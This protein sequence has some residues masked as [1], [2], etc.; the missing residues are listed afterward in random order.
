MDYN[1][2]P[3]FV[4]G[5]LRHF[6]TAS[7][8]V[9]VSKMRLQGTHVFVVCWAGHASTFKQNIKYFVQN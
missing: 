6:E 9:Q 3:H 4:K 2:P 7:L 5:V 1:Y 8:S